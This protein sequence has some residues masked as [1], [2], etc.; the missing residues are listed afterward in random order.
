[1]SETVHTHKSYQFAATVE[2]HEGRKA[3]KMLAE[4]YYRTCI[5]NFPLGEKLSVTVT[6][7]RGKRTGQQN[8]FYW[9]Y[10]GMIHE[11][12]GNEIDDLHTL[13]KGLFLSQGIT[14]VFGEKVRK[15]KSTTDLNIVEFSD[16][17]RNI[18]VKTGILAPDTRN[19]WD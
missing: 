12:T 11:E 3:L 14:E 15:V 6:S 19:Y 5:N 1:M 2:L 4:P 8:K 13:F 10:L 17:I 7:H 18:E 9:H 16:Y